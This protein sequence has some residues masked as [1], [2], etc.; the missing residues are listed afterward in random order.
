MKWLSLVAF[1]FLRYFP[2]KQPGKKLNI[3]KRYRN[4]KRLE[5]KNVDA[6]T[7]FFFAMLN[8][9]DPGFSRET[10]TKQLTDCT[11]V[12]GTRYKHIWKIQN[13]WHNKCKKYRNG[14]DEIYDY[15]W[16]C[17]LLKS[18][19]CIFFHTVCLGLLLFLSPLSV[20]S[21]KKSKALHSLHS[22]RF[23]WFKLHCTYLVSFNIFLCPTCSVIYRRNR[24]VGNWA[25]LCG[26][27]TAIESIVKSGADD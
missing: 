2:T 6:V 25:L 1:G 24:R 18:V 8:F 23:F 7:W 12:P 21:E 22:R 16:N 14:K 5:K 15:F 4:T 9:L 13:M 19:S 26:L 10:L 11:L 17:F 3:V 27:S 20:S